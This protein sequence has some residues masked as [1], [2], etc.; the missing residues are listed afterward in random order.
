MIGRADTKHLRSTRFNKV[1][2]WPKSGSGPGGRRFKSSL[3]DHLFS[4]T[5]SLPEVL[6][7]DHLDLDQV[8]SLANRINTAFFIQ[9]ESGNH[10]KI[11]NKFRWRH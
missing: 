4:A 3:L 2:Q 11:D 9:T 8:P 6:R 1:Q 7:S 10:H 5:Y